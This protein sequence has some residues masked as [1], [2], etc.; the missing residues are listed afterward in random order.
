VADPEKYVPCPCYR[1]D[2]FVRFKSNGTRVITEIRLKILIHCDPAFQD[3]SK[4]PNRHES[5]GYVWR[6]INLP[7]QPLADFEPFSR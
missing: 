3:H 6:P 5:I 2:E 7:Y 1:A 4:S